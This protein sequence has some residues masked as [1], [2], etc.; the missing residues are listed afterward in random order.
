MIVMFYVVWLLGIYGPY[1]YIYIKFLKLHILKNK[2][3]NSDMFLK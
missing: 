1:I 3:I 2:N